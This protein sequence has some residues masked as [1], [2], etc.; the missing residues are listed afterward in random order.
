MR[1]STPGVHDDFYSVNRGNFFIT[2]DDVR[3]FTPPDLPLGSFEETITLDACLPQGPHT[4][5][6]HSFS[7]G[8]FPDLPAEI[9]E[10]SETIVTD[11]TPQVM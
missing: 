3:L 5:V 1:D 2:L 9:K 7:I 11:Y 4:F 8:G 10:G 6:V